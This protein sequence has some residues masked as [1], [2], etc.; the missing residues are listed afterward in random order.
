MWDGIV[1]DKHKLIQ[2]IV[3]TWTTFADLFTLCSSIYAD[4]QM[5]FYIRG[6]ILVPELA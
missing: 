2:K 1:V 4:K 3:V 5:V 6:F